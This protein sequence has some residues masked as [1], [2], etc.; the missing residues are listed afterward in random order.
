MHL[1][2]GYSG[3]QLVTFQG[4]ADVSSRTANGSPTLSSAPGDSKPVGY[5]SGKALLQSANQRIEEYY[6]SFKEKR[7][8]HEEAQ[9]EINSKEGPR[10]RL[11]HCH[12]RASYQ[13]WQR[14]PSYEVAKGTENKTPP[15]PF[16]P[17][18]T[19]ASQ[20]QA[21]AAPTTTPPD[22]LKLVEIAQVHESQLMKLAKAIPS[23]IQQAIKNAMQP[24][25]DKL[26]GL[27][28][29]V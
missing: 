18:N 1:N 25:R 7:S 10:S 13:N 3:R 4:N 23:L 15:P 8:I 26:N 2:V 21:V 28:T 24:A 11:H 12:I 29:I 20:F 9:F 17:S 16:V 14:C 27:R 22:L 19:P 6:V 5:S